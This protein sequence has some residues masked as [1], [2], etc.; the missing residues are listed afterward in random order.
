M[1][2]NTLNYIIDAIGF[3]AMAFLISTGAIMRF[4]LP[5][6]SGYTLAVWG[7]DRH[8]WGSIHFWLGVMFLVV[9]IVHIVLHWGWIVSVTRGSLE[10]RAGS[11]I[12]L[13]VIATVVVLALAAIPLLAP[14]EETG[15]APHRGRSERAQAEVSEI[16]RTHTEA[17]D[18]EGDRAEAADIEPDRT[19]GADVEHDTHGASNEHD[20]H[21]SMTLRDIEELTGVPATHILQELRLSSGVS[22][23]E[24]LGRLR[25]AHGFE[26]DEVRAIVESYHESK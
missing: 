3:V 13:A 12:W 16:E 14:V 15:E 7:M 26:I 21:G 19:E 22:V 9:V 24:R 17:A 8:V 18:V 20:I 4:V 10:S 25:R 6:G 1:K 23:D 11:R 2:R 5:A